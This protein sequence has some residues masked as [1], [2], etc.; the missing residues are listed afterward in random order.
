[1]RKKMGIIIE[2]GNFAFGEGIFVGHSRL[3]VK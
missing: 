2:K 1:M 3:R